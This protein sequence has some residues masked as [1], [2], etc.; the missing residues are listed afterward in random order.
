MAWPVEYGMKLLIYSQCIPRHRYLC[1]YIDDIPDK[2]IVKDI[3]NK[4]IIKV[5][6]VVEKTPDTS[7][8]TS[9]F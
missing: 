8:L 2:L 1:I 4:D 6:K 9:F 5:G 7:N 3:N